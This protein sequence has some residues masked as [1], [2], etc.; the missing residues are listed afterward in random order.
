[1]SFATTKVK[2]YYDPKENVYFDST[3]VRE[4]LPHYVE[5]TSEELSNRMD[6]LFAANPG[7]WDIEND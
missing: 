3:Q 4:V 7:R 1:M 5:L 6:A 2:Q